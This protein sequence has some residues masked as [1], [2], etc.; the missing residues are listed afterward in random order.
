MALYRCSFCTDK[1]RPDYLRWYQYPLLL[2][3]I[4]PY[5]C[6]HC[7]DGALRPITSLKRLFGTP[8]RKVSSGQQTNWS[9]DTTASAGRA[10]TQPAPEARKM[11]S[12]TARPEEGRTGS[13]DTK[14]RERP[15]KDSRSGSSERR[16]SRDADSE[17]T[18]N[19]RRS[20][21]AES[22]QS[23]DAK[24]RYLEIRS[25]TGDDAPASYGRSG[26]LRRIFKR[27]G[28]GIRRVFGVR[29]KPK[30]RS[31]RSSGASKGRK[32]KSSY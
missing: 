10:A 21:Q 9:G 16:R 29:R 12:S 23:R 6:P 27:I 30:R 19:S 4:R 8:N 22:S 13:D 17:P 24:R 5:Y 18:D 14:R 31:S 7:G 25:V 15:R 2:A 1:L 20:R 32:K 28:R 11:S 3:F 26:F